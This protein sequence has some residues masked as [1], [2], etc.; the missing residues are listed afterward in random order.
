M[1]PMDNSL[2]LDA[3]KG[4]SSSPTPPKA[5]LDIQ[6]GGAEYP[7]AKVYQLLQMNQQ[8]Q[9]VDRILHAGRYPVMNLGGGQIATH[10]MAWGTADGKAY[11][12]PTIVLQGGKLV[13]LSPDQAFRHAMSTGEY[14]A[15]DRPE[16]AEWF[17]QAYKMWM[18]PR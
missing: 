1:S 5:P 7:S 8:K 11:M 17:S 14:I 13:E 4:L 2:A 15:F 18:Q 9:F 10:K 16:E 12:Y 6:A 3:L